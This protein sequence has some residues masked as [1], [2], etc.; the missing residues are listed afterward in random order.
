LKSGQIL[1]LKKKMYWFLEKLRDGWR[2]RRGEIAIEEIQTWEL[3]DRRDFLQQ[4]RWVVYF[5]SIIENF[6][7]FWSR[8]ITQIL[9]IYTVYVQNMMLF[10]AFNSCWYWRS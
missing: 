8:T 5:P 7:E 2:E 4:Q 3:T 9:N 10:F 1:R 6:G